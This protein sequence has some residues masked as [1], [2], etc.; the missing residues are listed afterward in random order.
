MAQSQS[1]DDESERERISA[2]DVSE[3]DRVFMGINLHGVTDDVP[4][5]EYDRDIY[6]SGVVGTVTEALSEFEKEMLADEDAGRPMADF[7][8][9]TD[10]GKSFTWN[11]DNGYVMGYNAKHDRHTDLGHFGGIYEA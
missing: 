11:V 9:E 4:G 7:R 2:T 6:Q 5:S 10:D 1:P 3:G 8:V